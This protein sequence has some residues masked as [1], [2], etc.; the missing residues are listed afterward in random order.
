M[1]F[2]FDRGPKLVD[3]TFSRGGQDLNLTVD[4]N[5]ATGASM[6]KIDTEVKAE[7]GSGL[8]TGINHNVAQMKALSRMLSKSITKWDCEDGPPEYEFFMTLPV[9]LLTDLATFVLNVGGPKAETSEA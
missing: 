5:A 8:N 9:G 6:E 1:G 2:K 3:D 4:V 7:L